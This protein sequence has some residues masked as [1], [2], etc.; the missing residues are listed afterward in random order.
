[1]L[2]LTSRVDRL[3]AIDVDATDTVAASN[4]LPGATLSRVRATTFFQ[5]QS[6]PGSKAC[7]RSNQLT[8]M[9]ANTGIMIAH[10]NGLLRAQAE[11]SSSQPT[12]G[13][14]HSA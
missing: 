10:R 3:R 13:S 1:M 14:A 5:N 9:P 8:K 6:T 11:H 2:R 7:I 12:V 4:Q